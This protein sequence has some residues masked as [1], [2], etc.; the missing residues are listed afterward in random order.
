MST[1]KRRQLTQELNKQIRILTGTSVIFSKV[2]A[3]KA[4]QHSTDL[5]CLDFL[6]LNGPATAGRLA[7]MTGLTTGAVTAMIDRLEQAGYAQRERDKNDRRKVIV[8]PN[9]T[10]INAEIAPY[11]RSMGVALETLSKEFSE[12][13]LE[14][15][16]RFLTKANSAGH[17]EIS[18]LRKIAE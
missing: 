8:V 7:E 4:G 15:I 10:R 13:E 14:I 12:D 5:E 3:D 9:E 2:I 11:S 1:P 17:K 6:Q 16:L 18:K